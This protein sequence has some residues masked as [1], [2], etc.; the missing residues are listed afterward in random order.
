MVDWGLL[1]F[2]CGCFADSFSAITRALTTSATSFPMVLLI[3]TTCCRAIA[4][5]MARPVNSVKTDLHASSISDRIQVAMTLS[6]SSFFVARS[7]ARCSRTRCSSLA[8]F[9]AS[10]A[11]ACVMCS[12]SI[13]LAFAAASDLALAAS[14]RSFATSEA[15]EFSC[16]FRF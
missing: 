10:F 3:R 5:P 2:E 12:S 15:S 16:C 6:T 8:Y 1:K 9:A 4:A 13:S 14:A 11:F 7:T